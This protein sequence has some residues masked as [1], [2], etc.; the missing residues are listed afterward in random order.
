MIKIE[1]KNINNKDFYYISEQLLL[2]GKKKK[3]QVYVGKKI[4]KE[5]FE[6]CKKLRQKEVD[7]I[8]LYLS[9][10]ELDGKITKKEYEKIEK[11]RIDWKYWNFLNSD[12]KKELKWREFSI[13]FIY[14]SNAIEGSKLSKIEVEK[15]IKNKYVKKSI[16]RNEVLEARNSICVFNIIRDKN[17][18]LN[19]RS[20]IKLHTL[21][22]K[23]LGIEVGFKKKEIVINNKNT[24]PPGKVRGDLAKLLT[25]YCNT[26]KKKSHP[27][28]LATKF[29][30]RFEA[31]HPFAD[32]NGRVGRLIYNWMLIQSRYGS[33][34]IQNKNRSAYFS[35]LNQADEG[36]NVKL[37][38]FCFR[39]YHKAIDYFTQ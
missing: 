35:A 1:K 15:I 37:Y 11:I 28:L 25:W 7:L 4:P 21:L 36:R 22:T 19:Q 10:F 34:L 20:I 16:E 29:H 3:I 26:K 39:A 17:F 13:S 38:R 5:L 31:I 2:N 14:E 33:I 18:R 12:F 30:Q 23:G 9:G 24:T 32:G 8:P 6:Y 27:L